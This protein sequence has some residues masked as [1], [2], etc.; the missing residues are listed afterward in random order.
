MEWEIL[1][2]N[3]ISNLLEQVYNE[4]D[5]KLK[6]IKDKSK[7]RGFEYLTLQE[8]NYIRTLN[9]L[10]SV[11]I[12]NVSNLLFELVITYSDIYNE[13]KISRPML[14]MI[15]RGTRNTTIKALRKICICISNKNPKI[16][17]SLIMEA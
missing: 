2:T 6:Y 8:Y 12:K 7:R 15:L 11:S 1:D 13:T 4:N 3:Y 5:N 10:K 14:S 16:D 9:G 17:K